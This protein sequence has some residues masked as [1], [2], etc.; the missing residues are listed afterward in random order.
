MYLPVET[1][2]VL[3]MKKHA[4]KASKFN[5]KSVAAQLVVQ[6]AGRYNILKRTAECLAAKQ[7]NQAISWTRIG[8]LQLCD[9]ILKSE[10]SD[11]N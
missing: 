5:S 8:P 3:Y 10:R 4:L 9:T 2:D 7:E 1:K 6:M 11:T